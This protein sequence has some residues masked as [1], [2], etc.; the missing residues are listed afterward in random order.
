MKVIIQPTYIC[1]NPRSE[2]DDHMLTN[3]LNQINDPIKYDLNLKRLNDKL[4]TILSYTDI[5]EIV[6]S[7]NEISTL[8]ENYISELL[9]LCNIYCENVTIH[10]NMYNM[11]VFELYDRYVTTYIIPYNY[12][13][14]DFR[15]VKMKLSRL[16]IKYKSKVTLQ[17]VLTR[18]IID[19]PTE[20]LL[21]DYNIY[22]IRDVSII[23][24][25]PTAKNFYNEISDTECSNKLKDI[26]NVWKSRHY[27]F[28]LVNYEELSNCL[29]YK[30]NPFM[31]NS[32]IIGAKGLYGY[33]TCN[34][35]LTY[36]WVRRF[37]DYLKQCELEKNEYNRKCHM[38]KYYG[39][40]YTHHLNLSK[41]CS[42]NKDLL[43]F[44]EEAEKIVD[45]GP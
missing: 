5:S 44:L 3:E 30:N 29:K 20:Q 40:C 21:E 45:S 13:R 34:P 18:D 36:N 11:N 6:I 14:K 17:T 19:T 26:I 22:G 32:V 28:K 37:S 41:P 31:E 4:N 1:V 9:S 35:Y 27:K 39:R 24:H 23:K 2:K 15:T 38:C 12:D 8:D 16:H 10:T 7:G 43:E 42:G 33:I 25:R